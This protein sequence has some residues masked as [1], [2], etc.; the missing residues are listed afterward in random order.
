MHS[1]APAAQERDG[2]AA[3]PRPCHETVRGSTIMGGCRLAR[4]RSPP[5][6]GQGRAR[7]RVDVSFSSRLDEFDLF[8]GSHCFIMKAPLDAFLLKSCI[9]ITRFHSQSLYSLFHFSGNGSS[10]ESSSCGGTD[11]AP[12]LRSSPCCSPPG[13]TPPTHTSPSH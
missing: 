1:K 9:Q 8:P 6:P 3:E 5:K 7:S 11:L 10:N 2:A 12:I 13:P 4:R